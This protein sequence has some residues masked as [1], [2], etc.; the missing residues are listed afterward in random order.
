MLLSAAPKL[1]WISFAWGLCWSRAGK[2]H[3]PGSSA[4]YKR[5]FPP[6]QL[7]AELR[8]WQLKYFL[9]EIFI[10]VKDI[11]AFKNKISPSSCDPNSH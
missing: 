5:P 10:F 3:C 2:E 8:C 4:F 11:V 7:L 6:L 9:T 1:I